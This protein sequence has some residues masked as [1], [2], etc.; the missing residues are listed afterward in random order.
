M[1]NEIGV[2]MDVDSMTA[3]GLLLLVIFLRGGRKLLILG[4]VALIVLAA[5]RN[6]SSKEM[7]PEP[8]H[9]TDPPQAPS[10]K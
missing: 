8:E 1:D 6:R 4:V 2:A 5:S 10:N 7:R 9:P 3:P